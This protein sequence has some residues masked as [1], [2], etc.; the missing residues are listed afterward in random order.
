[1]VPLVL[2]FLLFKELLQILKRQITGEINPTPGVCST[3]SYNELET[4]AHLRGHHVW[5]FSSTTRQFFNT[6]WMSCNATQFQ[7]GPS[8]D[9]VRSHRLGAQ[10][11]KTVPTVDAKLKSRCF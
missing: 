11:Q 6:S 2:F 10:P 3:Y 9:S 8:G 4:F 1:M 7:H 5:F